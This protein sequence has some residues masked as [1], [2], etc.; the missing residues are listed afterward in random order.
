[1][2]AKCSCGNDNLR[3][4]RYIIG[5]PPTIAELIVVCESCRYMPPI[6]PLFDRERFLDLPAYL[7]EDAER[8]FA[9]RR[10]NTFQNESTNAVYPQ[11]NFMPDQKKPSE[12]ERAIDDFI[13]ENW[14]GLL[15]IAIIIF[16][17]WAGI[18][19]DPAP[20]SK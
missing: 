16:C 12:L 10:W 20:Y 2:I 3:F 14:R 19:S 8:C 11:G 6:E 1:M 15:L 18:Q 4:T 17:F 9:V 7:F 5:S 13:Q